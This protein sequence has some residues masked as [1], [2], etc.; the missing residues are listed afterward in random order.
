M[1]RTSAEKKKHA[2]RFIDVDTSK[3]WETLTEFNDVTKTYVNF[4]QAVYALYPGLEEEHKWSVA[5]MDKL[6]GEQSCLGVL[7]L[8]DLGEYHHHFLVI[9]TL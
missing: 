1:F 2:C 5:N 4:H 8:G 9:T 7:L 3:L 6:V